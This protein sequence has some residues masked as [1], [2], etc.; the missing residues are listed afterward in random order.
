MAAALMTS[1]VAAPSVASPG[2]AGIAAGHN[3]TVFHNIDF[4]A[5]FGYVI[6]VPITVDVFRGP[7]P[8]KIGTATG[9]AVGGPDG[10]ALEVNH[11]PLLAPELGD[12]WTGSTP[13]IRP[14]DLIRVTQGTTVDEVIVDD[15]GFSGPPVVVPAA[16]ATTLGPPTEEIHV[17]G[18]ARTFNGTPIPTAQLDSAE[19]RETAQF[20]GGP[21]RVDA[22]ASVAGGGGFILVYE[23]PDYVLVGMRNTAGLNA[24]QRRQSLLGDGHAV[25][26][27][28]VAPLP[29]ESMLVDGIT[30]TPGPALGCEG[31]PAAVDAVTNISQGGV[32][33][34]VINSAAVAA[35][36]Q[37]TISGLSVNASVVNVSINDTD[38]VTAAV[39]APAATP[40][41]SVG[42]GTWSTTVGMADLAGLSDS[43]LTFSMTGAVPGRPKMIDKDT[44][45]PGAPTVNPSAGAYI[46]TQ[47]VTV[48]AAPGTSV[49]RWTNNGIDPTVAS[50]AVSGQIA[51]TSS[52]TLKARGFDA[53]GNASPVLTAA[54]TI[55]QPAVPA[56]PSGLTAAAGNGSAT[57]GWSVPANNGAPITGYRVRWF[58]GGAASPTGTMTVTNP[59]AVVTGLTNG[60]S[61]T[62]DVA[63]INGV[64]VGPASSRSSAVT[65]VGVPVAVTVPRVAPVL[66][67]GPAAPRLV[68]T[69]PAAVPPAVVP[70]AVVPP[71]AV[72]PRVLLPKLVP[73]APVIGLARSG[74]PGGTVTAKARWAAPASDGGSAVKGYRVVAQQVEAGHVVGVTR[75][76]LV[77]ADRRGLRMSLAPGAY[78]FKVKAVNEVGRSP[79]SGRSNLVTAR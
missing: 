78:R 14:G 10:G 6:G 47:Q 46:G 43:T 30:D 55:T 33:L 69:P 51:I 15:I 58:I 56:A 64:G 32:S 11:G 9:P 35:G 63:A 52:Q 28:H 62:F 67:A 59:S 34:P 16:T 74:R 21:N 42:S 41:T 66:P 8:V 57:L 37:V 73:G 24:A 75:S 19:F 48:T 13:D 22:D 23:G 65:P 31:S 7:V 71:A 61:Y 45:A 26:F 60:T 20:R 17:K 5:V 29:A 3:I 38:A 70:P 36:G 1:V 18:W 79:V 53:A 12:C 39:V 40:S 54:Y 50:S 25:G 44:V 2:P 4:V 49:L 27:G 72:P 76:G 77:A 68:A